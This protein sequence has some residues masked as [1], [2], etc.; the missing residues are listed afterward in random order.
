[1]ALFKY[2]L[3]LEGLGHGISE[4][5]YF[6]SNDESIDN[7]F[8]FVAS[9][10][11]KRIKL[12]GA[13]CY[14]KGAR[15]ALVEDNAGN[16]VERISAVDKTNYFSDVTYPPAESN[17]SLQVL[18]TT[19]DQKHKKIM[20]LGFPFRNVFV[21]GDSYVPGAAAAG[22]WASFFNSWVQIC[23]S[24]GLGW[25]TQTIDQEEDITAYT[26]DPATGLTTFTLK[27]PGLTWPA[28]V[29]SQRVTVEFPGGKK[30]LDGTYDVSP[31]DATHCISVKPRPTSP[32]TV[33]GKM[34][35]YTSS[36]LT[37]QT[38]NPLGLPGTI[39]GQNPVTRKRGRPLLVSR[40]RLPVRPL[41]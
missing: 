5:L 16:D 8:K 22:P 3:I 27:A 35:I 14:I 21:G 39:K 36:F 15:M 10:P 28:G 17:V 7:A 37:V 31:I 24:L 18:W 12:I 25:N 40:G 41:W 26:F 6:Q 4:S 13:G 33:K 34:R 29:T 2:T 9:Y 11:G 19:S 38:L 32:F 23:T 30:S 1:M 20:F